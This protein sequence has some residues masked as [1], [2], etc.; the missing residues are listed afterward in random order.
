MSK[1][2]VKTILILT[3]LTLISACEPSATDVSPTATT[4][5]PSP[6][7]VPPTATPTEAPPTATPP[8][9][10]ALVPPTNAPISPTSTPIPPTATAQPSPPPTEASS[11]AYLGQ[12]PPGLT[13]QVF[14]PGIISIPSATDYAGSFSPDGTEFYFT[15]RTEASQNIYETHLSNGVW[16]E[17]TPVAFS[18]GYDAHE[19]HVTFDNQ[20]LYFGWFR[21]PPPGEKSTMPAGI[22]ATDRTASG[23]ASPRYVGEGM[24]VSSDR[25]GHM[26]VTNVDTRSVGQVT[27]TNGRFTDWKL[28]NAGA[29]PCIA[30]DGSYLL[31]DRDGTHMFVKFRLADG[32]WSAAKDL[33][34]HG[35]PVKAGI[36]SISPDGNYLFYGYQGDLYWVSTEL[37]INLENE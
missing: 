15:R 20:T 31:Y 6:T 33:T 34:Q 10:T 36:A 25:S 32:K 27:V 1:S 30:P 14:A 29:H 2:I 26:Y 16:S 35:M 11:N 24:A 21:P 17:P 28:I 18:A 3:L 12:V 23:W 7:V 5:P 8:P 13:P 22:W 9:P 19:P 4:V 37:I